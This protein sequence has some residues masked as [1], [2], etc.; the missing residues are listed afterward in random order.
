MVWLISYKQCM[1]KQ[2]VASSRQKASVTL[3]AQTF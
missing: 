2:N 1:L 3:W